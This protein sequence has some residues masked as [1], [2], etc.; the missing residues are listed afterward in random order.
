MICARLSLTSCAWGTDV[1]PS[2]RVREGQTPMH[3]TTMQDTAT[4]YKTL[5]YIYIYIYIYIVTSSTRERVQRTATYCITLRHTTSHCNTFA[6]LEDPSTHRAYISICDDDSTWNFWYFSEWLSTYRKNSV[7]VTCSLWGEN[8]TIHSQGIET[9]SV[10]PLD[11]PP[12]GYIHSSSLTRS[13]LLLVYL[14]PQ[15]QRCSKVACLHVS[16]SSRAGL[17]PR[18]ADDSGEETNCDR[19]WTGWRTIRGAG[20]IGWELRAVSS[21]A[22]L[23]PGASPNP[24]RFLDR[25]APGQETILARCNF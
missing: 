12:I 16:K 8:I 19:K 23:L 22:R 1:C 21:P 18:W 13:I 10:F 6:S 9:W 3:C 14:P 25:Y 4:N 20:W 7:L 5:Y 2:R 11:I 17:R 15:K 24:V